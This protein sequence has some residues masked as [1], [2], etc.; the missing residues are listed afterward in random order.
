[1]E[2]TRNC[3]LPVAL[4]SEVVYHQER[5]QARDE[6]DNPSVL[7]LRGDTDTRHFLQIDQEQ[8]RQ[9][10]VERS[11]KPPE[12]RPWFG[13][14]TLWR[15]LD[16]IGRS[17]LTTPIRH[18]FGG[19]IGD[20]GAGAGQEACEQDG[21]DKLHFRRGVGEKGYVILII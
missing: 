11:L 6:R 15:A 17:T 16:L 21:G 19:G 7:N 14:E 5:D 1:M 9:G 13:R 3:S 8:R 18:L 4:E 10:G 2:Y 12:D 20:H